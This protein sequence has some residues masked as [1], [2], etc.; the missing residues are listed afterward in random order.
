MTEGA[1][2]LSPRA[3]AWLRPELDELTAYQVA[4]A[5]DLIKLDAMEN[6]YGWP[7]ELIPE[8]QERLAA[9]PLNRYPDGG[10]RR[11]REQL[12][13]TLGL[14]AGLEVILGN[15]SDELIQLLIQAVAGSGRTVLAPE[16]TFVM[17]RQL[18]RANGLAFVGVPLA[19]DF[20]LD[21]PA[22]AEA[23]RREQPALVF[24]AWPNNPTGNL[25]D[26]EAVEAVIEAAPGLVVIDE[27]YEPFAQASYADAPRVHDHV[28]VL[29]TLSKLGLAGLRLGYLLGAPG[30]V[31]ELDKLRLPYNISSLT[32]ATAEFALSHY[33]V[34]SE[35]AA[36]IR[37]DRDVLR[38][39]LAAVPGVAR[40]WPSAANFLLFRVPIGQAGAVHEGLRRRGVLIKN[41]DG[42]HPQLGDCLRVTVGRPGENDV[43]L[44]ALGA[45]L[46]ETGRD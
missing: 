10:A 20:A 16:P 11:L 45:T 24:L 37:A 33:A 27:A 4:D 46:A 18:A 34:L 13:A 3:R 2:G 21:G 14:P 39:R 1:K 26:P 36:R 32:Q 7:P 6:P 29:R 23:C 43:F 22:M 5:G 35:Q 28:M 31:A 41:L 38:G 44:E 8:W 19:E 25:F 40:V 9:V 15:G 30:L 42:A 17:Y 12:T